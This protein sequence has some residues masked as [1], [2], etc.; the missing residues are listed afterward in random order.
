MLHQFEWICSSVY[1]PAST[2]NSINSSYNIFEMLFSLDFSFS[3]EF[4]VTKSVYLS[5]QLNARI[6]K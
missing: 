4:L 1:P 5:R 6:Q 3:R 2:L